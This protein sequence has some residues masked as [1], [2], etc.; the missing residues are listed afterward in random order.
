MGGAHRS[1]CYVVVLCN[2]MLCIPSVNLYHF[3][4]PYISPYISIIII[5]IILF[6]Q[7][8]LLF[9]IFLSKSIDSPMNFISI[10][11]IVCSTII[12]FNTI[13]LKE[14]FSIILSVCLSYN[15][16]TLEQVQ[17]FLPDLTKPN[18]AQLN[19]TKLNHFVWFEFRISFSYHCNV[20]HKYNQT[21]NK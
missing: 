10:I 7:I 14:L 2:V 12:Q 16:E 15:K 19:S 9:L 1:Q 3:I 4:H 20:N 5:N 13:K 6:N 18:S 17:V 11:S 8:Y 21:S